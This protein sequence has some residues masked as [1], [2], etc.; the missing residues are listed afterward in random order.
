MMKTAAADTLRKA[1][2][3]GDAKAQFSLGVCYQNGWG[4]GRDT[5]EAAKWYSKAAEQGN[6]DAGAALDAL[7][8][9]RRDLNE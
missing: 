6:A 7:D 8:F 1:A 5:A 3:R 4:V 9:S 2:E